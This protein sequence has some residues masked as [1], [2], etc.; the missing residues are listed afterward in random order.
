MDNL[1]AQEMSKKYQHTVAQIFM[2][3]TKEIKTVYFDG[4]ALDT[5]QPYCIVHI[6]KKKQSKKELIHGVISLTSDKL[7]LNSFNILPMPDR[8]VFD[9]G[10]RTL[11]YSRLPNRQWRKGLTSDNTLV[12][13]PMYSLL[14]EIPNRNNFKLH[15][16]R[17]DR[18]GIKILYNLFIQDYAGS[19]EKALQDIQ[20]LDLLSRAISKD[21]WIGC[22]LEEDKP[23]ILYRHSIPVAF[24]NNKIDTLIPISKVYLQEI[25]DFC[26]R[27]NLT[28]KIEV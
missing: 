1:L 20:E 19:V 26:N 13:D 6:N 7:S 2:K 17:I 28:A 8:Q 22:F 3:A 16:E 25:T 9:Y 18:Y 27:F 4:F 15:I 21:Y 10:G 12:E 23:F 24:Y 5:T 14:S 11:V